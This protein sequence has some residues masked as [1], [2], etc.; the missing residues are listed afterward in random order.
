MNIGTTFEQ[1]TRYSGGNP[2][3]GA[4]RTRNN[5]H[6]SGCHTATG[7]RCGLVSPP[8]ANQRSCLN[9]QPRSPKAFLKLR[10]N[11]HLNGLFGE[12]NLMRS[13]AHDEVNAAFLLKQQL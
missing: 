5:H 1:I 6:A 11:G 12:P 13:T 2:S 7:N 9:I 10:I 4:H 3:H 8:M